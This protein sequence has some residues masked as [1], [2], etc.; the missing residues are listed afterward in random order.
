MIT[1]T[2]KLVATSSLLGLG[3]SDPSL[4]S[5]KLAE[6][7]LH[8]QLL[9]QGSLSS[10]E[11][12]PRVSKRV[13]ERKHAYSEGRKSGIAR[14]SPNAH[15]AHINLVSDNSTTTTTTAGSW[16]TS[17]WGTCHANCG[18]GPQFREVTC[19]APSGTV[20]D[21]SFCDAN[22]RPTGTQT[23]Q[24][25]CVSCA[26][27]GKFLKGMGASAVPDLPVLAPSDPSL[28]ICAV[29][30]TT[31]TCCTAGVEQ[32][33]Q[34]FYSQL[35]RGMK[36]QTMH[37]DRSIQR[38]TD[39]YTNITDVINNR[40]TATTDASSA[41]A[42]AIDNSPAV[43][44]SSSSAATQLQALRTVLSEALDN[45]MESLQIALSDLSV[46]QDEISQQL[47]LMDSADSDL[48]EED[49]MLTNLTLVESIGTDLFSSMYSSLMNGFS[50]PETQAVERAYFSDADVGANVAA[51]VEHRM[52]E[53]S[54]NRIHFDTEKKTSSSSSLIETANQT[55]AV[56]FTDPNIRIVSKTCETA[57]TNYFSGLACAACNP[58]FP[59]TALD[60]PRNPYVNLS[61]STCTG[62]YSSCADSL[63]EAHGHLVS[64][65]G[66]LLNSHGNLIS[67]AAQLQPI[68]D[69]IWAE[70]R[71][72]W[73]PGFSLSQLAKPNITSMACIQDLAVFA[74]F[75]IGNATNF[76][77]GYFSYASPRAFIQRISVQ[78]DRGVFA[79]A[80][81]ASCDRCL[82]STMMFL[83]DVL[84]ET[85]KGSLRVSL[86]T[87]ANDM[88]VNCGAGRIATAPAAGSNSTEFM[89]YMTPSE[90]ISPRVAFPASQSLQGLSYYAI[91]AHATLEQW[92]DAPPSEW[93]WR[94]LLDENNATRPVP[95]TSNTLTSNVLSA[96]AMIQL[97][98]M[99]QNCT[100]H[101]ECVSSNGPW[102]FC[103][104]PNVCNA[105]GGSCSSEAQAFLMSGPKCARGPCTNPLSAIDKQCPDNAVCPAGPNSDPPG[106]PFFGQDYFAKFDSKLRIDDPIKN[107]T[108]LPGVCDC[109][110]DNNGIVADPCE[111]AR[112]LAYASL[113]E[114]RLTCTSGL[115]S[116][117]AAIKKSN[118]QCASDDTLSCADKDT[119]LL[120]PPA[121]AG[122]CNVNDIALASESKDGAVNTSPMSVGNF[123]LIILAAI[124]VW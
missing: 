40:L 31:Y 100:A 2:L 56:N 89:S 108:T 35:R 72:D 25:D 95:A 10:S 24:G 79:M 114:D 102:W 21:A 59:I 109:A 113:V 87:T 103:A 16:H 8:A 53:K 4:E 3:S 112:C 73:L 18:S 111:F 118:S 43:S 5:V 49:D 15:Q 19:V 78:L 65:I 7:G 27:N 116:Q 107:A 55:T 22:T 1:R 82:H 68:L 84:G 83:A 6:S 123:V 86:P 9:Q 33:I 121:M 93:T 96:D 41:I 48:N 69:Q 97:H 66:S 14:K 47:A 98:V 36:S 13:E 50:S 23:C 34:I 91:A 117:C 26:V 63:V 119:I 60:P 30:N 51:F 11:S 105:Q 54:M 77:D 62:L 104:H 115:T 29:Q 85:N 80:K 28:S 39:L 38:V 81:F 45:R 124:A 70:L 120:Y 57:I 110:F 99:N 44:A 12:A 32:Q 94:S 42:A 58:S 64:G 74:P 122:E 71:F 76:C 67:L 75:V 61:P 101:A 20:L 37:R 17:D 46:A 106:Q 92:A 88:L 52:K 90:R